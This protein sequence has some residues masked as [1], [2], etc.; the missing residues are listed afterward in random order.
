MYVCI[1]AAP[2]AS[3]L[4]QR[5]NKS[6]LVLFVHGH[7]VPGVGD[8]DHAADFDTFKRSIGIALLY[9]PDSISSDRC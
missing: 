9:D 6:H 2:S 7:V 4:K 8:E 5:N 3:N 1:Y